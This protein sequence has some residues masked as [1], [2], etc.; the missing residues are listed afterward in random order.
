M[1][2]FNAYA[3]TVEM[4]PDVDDKGAI[5]GFLYQLI[6]DYLV[7]FP[8]NT[9]R[10]LLHNPDSYSEANTW[11]SIIDLNIDDD[12]DGQEKKRRRAWIGVMRVLVGMYHDVDEAKAFSL[13]SLISIPVF[14]H[15]LVDD[16]DSDRVEEVHDELVSEVDDDAESDDDKAAPAHDADV[17]GEPVKQKTVA[18]KK[19]KQAKSSGSGSKSVKIVRLPR[20]M[21]IDPHGPYGIISDADITEADRLD[22]A[23]SSRRGEV[24]AALS[25]V[26]IKR[27]TDAMRDKGHDIDNDSLLP[28]GR[29]LDILLLAFLDDGSAMGK[30]YAGGVKLGDLDRDMLEYAAEKYA[31]NG[32]VTKSMAQMAGDLEKLANKVSRLESDNADTAS[33]AR[34]SAA[35]SSATL[36]DRMNMGLI[37]GG[38]TKDDFNIADASLQEFI[39]QVKMQDKRH[40]NMKKERQGRAFAKAKRKGN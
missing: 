13:E 33:Y 16:G 10:H 9:L 19:Q 30:G 25:D 11:K 23:T 3:P 2:E 8:E 39:E 27:M 5:E 29:V 4:L 35:M 1:V 17:D 6:E 31:Y 26:A 36:S 14:S 34:I 38:V 12:L 20:T 18:K 24:N 32:S 37:P 21:K 40:E 28:I 22:A 7:D 15:V